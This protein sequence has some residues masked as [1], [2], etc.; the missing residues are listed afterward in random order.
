MRPLSMGSWDIVLRS[1]AR[2]IK[3]KLSMR[4]TQG[5]LGV[6]PQSVV[7]RIPHATND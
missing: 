7:N 6:A 1:S 3:T 2:L 5:G 4:L